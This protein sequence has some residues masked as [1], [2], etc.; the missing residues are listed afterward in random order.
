MVTA[1]SS[2]A[3]ITTPV[4]TNYSLMLKFKRTTLLFWKKRY[5]HNFVA[6][7]KSDAMVIKSIEQRGLCIVDSHV[8]TVRTDTER[9]YLS[10]KGFKE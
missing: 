7:N 3:N 8:Q 2:E 6:T 4:N 10:S 1:S 9:L 5:P